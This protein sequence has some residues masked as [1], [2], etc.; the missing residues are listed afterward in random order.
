MPWKN[1]DAPSHNSKTEDKSELQ[2][3]AG[4]LRPERKSL[5]SAL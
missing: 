1:T 2:E 4:G 3:A 5:Y